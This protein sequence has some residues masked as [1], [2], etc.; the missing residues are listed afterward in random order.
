MHAIQSHQAGS[1]GIVTKIAS[2]HV[3]HA[4][5]A[6]LIIGIAVTMAGVL[7]ECQHQSEL[8]KQGGNAFE[9]YLALLQAQP[10]DSIT[11]YAIAGVQLQLPSA[12]GNLQAIG[13]VVCYVAA[14]LVATGLFAL[15]TIGPKPEVDTWE[16]VTT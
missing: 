15:R 8:L 13:L 11:H 5:L 1:Q 3:G 16:L 2:V 6:I 9:A 12:G 14:P 10:I 4:I 7:T